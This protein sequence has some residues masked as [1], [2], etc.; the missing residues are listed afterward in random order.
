MSLIFVTVRLVK[1]EWAAKYALL[2]NTADVALL[3]LGR[4]SIFGSPLF[5]LDYRQTCNQAQIM[6]V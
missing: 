3:W 4:A 6:N 1:F 5:F 2:T